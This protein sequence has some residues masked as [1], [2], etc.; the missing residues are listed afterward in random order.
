MGLER[1][2]CHDII[3]NETSESMVQF[4]TGLKHGNAQHQ[5]AWL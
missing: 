1:H 5:D 4:M 2:S 3:A